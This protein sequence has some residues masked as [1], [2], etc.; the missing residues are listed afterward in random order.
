LITKTVQSVVPGG[1]GMTVVAAWVASYT[2]Q[3]SKIEEIRIVAD[4]RLSG[5]YR[6]D[7]A[8][9]I[10]QFARGDCAIAFAGDIGFAYPLMLQ[11]HGAIDSYRPARTRAFTIDKLRSHLL[12]IF[13]D[14]INNCLHDVA[15]PNDEHPDISF[16]FAGYNSTTKRCELFVAIWDRANRR[17]VFQNADRIRGRE[18]Y[19]VVIGDGKVALLGEIHNIVARNPRHRPWKWE[20]FE[21][22]RNFCRNANPQDTV[23]GTPQVVKIYQ[24][25]STADVPIFWPNIASGQIALRGRILTAGERTDHREALDPDSFNM[26]Q[27]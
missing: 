10:M 9:K 22:L 18:G 17:F 27:I 19:L 13:N 25:S 26:S 21:A 8:P 5:G 6:F 14:I 15:H 16:I 3:N 1:A 23:G 12:R 7:A 24:H 4:S 11:M 2:G 20:P